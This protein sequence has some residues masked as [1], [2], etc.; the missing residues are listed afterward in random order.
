[1]L[2]CDVHQLLFSH[3]CQNLLLLDV[4]YLYYVVMCADMLTHVVR[5]EYM[6]C[7]D[8]TLTEQSAHV[9]FDVTTQ[10]T[11][12]QHCHRLLQHY[13]ICSFHQIVE[14]AIR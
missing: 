3:A 9:S 12:V 7:I 8:E 4:H 10:H 6:M 2:E 5:C 11:I 14:H 13:V 1:M